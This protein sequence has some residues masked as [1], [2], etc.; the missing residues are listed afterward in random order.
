MLFGGK[1]AAAD[2]RGPVL[3]SRRSRV[4][5]FKLAFH[6]HPTSVWS[7]SRLGLLHFNKSWRRKAAFSVTSSRAGKDSSNSTT[8]AASLHGKTSRAMLQ[9]PP[10]T[11]DLTLCVV[12][13]SSSSPWRHRGRLHVNTTYPRMRSGNAH[14]MLQQ[15]HPAGRPSRHSKTRMYNSLFSHPLEKSNLRQHSFGTGLDPHLRETAM[16]LEYSTCYRTAHRASDRRVLQRN[17]ET[18]YMRR[19]AKALHGSQTVHCQEHHNPPASATS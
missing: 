8:T 10:S 1:K 19:P 16:C 2:R 15:R 4:D 9:S 14:Q 11:K 3:S 7:C 5:Q 13:S 6:V 17:M 18:P 12:L